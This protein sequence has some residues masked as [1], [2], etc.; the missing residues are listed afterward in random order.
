MKK[1]YKELKAYARL[2]VEHVDKQ[3]AAAHPA[4]VRGI[5]DVLA[6][7]DAEEMR[8]SDLHPPAR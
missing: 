4:I 1:P 2:F 6:A 8:S 3:M 5:R 7:I